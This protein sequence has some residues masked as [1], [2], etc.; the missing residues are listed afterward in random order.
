MD[1]L[2]GPKVVVLTALE[3]EYRA[4]RHHLRNLAV[5]THEA[6]TRF[7]TGLF[8][9]SSQIA[10][11]LVGE[12]NDAAAVLTER[13]IALFQPYALLFV[14]VA[15]GL[16][17]DIRLGDLVVGTKIY[18]YQG[19]K[20]TDE[21]FLSRPQAWEAPHWLEQIAH[22]VSRTGAWTSVLEA[23]VRNPRP[24]V[25]FK[26]IAAGDVVLNSRSTPLALQLHRTYNDAAAIETESAGVSKAAHLN[27]SLPALTIRGISDHAD[28]DKSAA[29]EEGW[30]PV[31]AATAAAFALT[32][33]SEIL[34]NLPVA[35]KRP[36]TAEPRSQK[37]QKI[38][39]KSGTAFSVMEGNIIFNGP[40]PDEPG[41]PGGVEADPG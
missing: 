18:A 2:E 3:L 29:D 10:L 40:R 9:D 11:A 24:D 17:N 33:A 32:L 30:Q 8:G 13:A 34:T 27:R 36:A 21:G 14:G 15:G 23:D 20:D 31:A 22:H 19:G 38:V 25:H 16:K 1:V 35:P 26:P 12:G 7:E 37:T 41:A 4:V 6:G 5:Q 39:V 28:G